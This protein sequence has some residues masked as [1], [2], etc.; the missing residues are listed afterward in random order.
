MDSLPQP[1]DKIQPVRVLPQLEEHEEEAKSGGVDD[2]VEF[3]AFYTRDVILFGA[4][5]GPE[6]GEPV[7]LLHGFPDFWLGWARQIRPLVEA[8]YRLIIPDQ[9]GYNHSEKPDDVDAYRLRETGTDVIDLLNAAEI[10]RAH[11]VGHDWGGA[12]SWWVAEHHSDRLE[13]VSILNCPHS[14]VLGKALMGNHPRQM[15]RSWY[16]ALFQLPRVPEMLA[17]VKNFGL[18]QKALDSASPGAFTEEEL[19]MYRRTWG[20]EGAL[21]AMLNWYRAARRE[22]LERREDGEL[23]RAQ[24]GGIT[25]PTQIIWGVH[26]AALDRSLVEPSAALCESAQVQWVDDATHWVQRDRPGVVTE[27]LLEFWG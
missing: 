7:V 18:L 16:I 8:G 21:T 23:H 13:T 22:T 15:L 9:R 14:R 27:R 11:L 19:A 2:L 25:T 12:V 17:K 3:R 26:D 5:A 20:R 4:I 1:D 6:D 10:E 24:P